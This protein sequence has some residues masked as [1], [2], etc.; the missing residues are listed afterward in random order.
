MKKYIVGLLTAALMFTQGC[1]MFKKDKL[2]AGGAYAATSTAAAMPELYITDSGFDVAYSALDTAFKYE[3]KNRATLWTI[4]PTI[5]KRLDNIR[6]ES[7]KVVLEYA[8]ARKIYLENPVPAN[9]TTLQTVLG[10]LQ[11]MNS[12]AMVIIGNK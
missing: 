10:K 8:L 9:L 11:T 5:K 4:S 7:S 2:E 12:S 1:A 3:Q 6:T